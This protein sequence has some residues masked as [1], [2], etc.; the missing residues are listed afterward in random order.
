MDTNQAQVIIE[1]ARRIAESGREIAPETIELLERIADS[2]LPV[3]VRLEA[4][5]LIGL[6]AMA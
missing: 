4:E 5:I 3:A 6:E 2:A 1:R